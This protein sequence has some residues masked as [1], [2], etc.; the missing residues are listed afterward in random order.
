MRSSALSRLDDA[1]IQALRSGFVVFSVSQSVEELIAN[2]IDAGATKIEVTLD[3]ERHS[4]QVKDNGLGIAEADLAQLPARY[5]TSK[6]HTLEDLSNIATL[7]WRG[8]ALASLAEVA[9]LQ[10]ISRPAQQP[11][12]AVKRVLQGTHATVAKHS[13][14]RGVGTTVTVRDLYHTMP[15]RRKMMDASSAKDA[16]QVRRMVELLCLAHPKLFLSLFDCKREQWLMRAKPCCDLRARFGQLFGRDVADSLLAITACIDGV[17]VSGLVSKIGCERASKDC[18]FILCNGRVVH[19]LQ[20]AARVNAHV[21]WA[22]R[23]LSLAADESD[24]RG[25]KGSPIKPKK[26]FPAF[27]VEVSCA[28]NAVDFHYEPAKRVVH[29]RKWYFPRTRHTPYTTHALV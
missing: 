5:H 17:A 3:L 1:A 25:T 18:Q 28:P 6:C 2:A 27:I 14:T 11:W 21:K 15:V 13:E 22:A 19:G 20:L 7:G 12:P 8:E 24:R 9:N 10:I 29:F 4:F 23:H 26:Q 16:A